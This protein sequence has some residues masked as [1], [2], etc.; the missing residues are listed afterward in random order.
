MGRLFWASLP[1]R[2]SRLTHTT[3]PRTR[4]TGSHP[5]RVRRK[6]IRRGRHRWKKSLSVGTLHARDP[7]I[8]QRLRDRCRARGKA[9]RCDFSIHKGQHIIGNIRTK[10]HTFQN[11]H[12]ALILAPHG[13]NPRG[14]HER[15]EFS[16]HRNNSGHVHTEPAEPA[17]PKRLA[18]LNRS[19][20]LQNLIEVQ[21]GGLV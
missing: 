18:V 20:A 2:F 6:S 13:L 4:L 16:C 11:T 7:P 8:H 21:L 19:A 14:V 3:D 1:R 15:C 10:L 17:P 9:T 12:D 5:A